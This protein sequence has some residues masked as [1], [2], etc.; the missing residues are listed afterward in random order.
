MATKDNS[1]N[2]MQITAPTAGCTA[3]GFTL[4][5]GILFF[6]P[7]AIT[8]AATGTGIW[9]DAC[10]RGVV[11]ATGSAWVKGQKLYWDNSAAKWTT[12]ATSNTMRGFAVAA[13]GSSDAT[14]DVELCQIPA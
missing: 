8:A 10:I 3:G 6:T 9:K 1:R 7:E 14:G 11:K 13:A 2:P 5:S 12:V 4:I